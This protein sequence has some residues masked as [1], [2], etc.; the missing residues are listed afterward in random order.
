[1]RFRQ[2]IDITIRRYWFLDMDD[3]TRGK[4]LLESEQGPN[5]INETDAKGRTALHIA[6]MN[7]NTK[8]ISLLMKKGAVF[9]K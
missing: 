7:G 4:R 6:S 8:I 5:I 1:M 2:F 3:I 9:T